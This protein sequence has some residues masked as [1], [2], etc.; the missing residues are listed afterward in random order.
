MMTVSGFRPI[1]TFDVTRSCPLR[2][3][4]C[5]FYAAP[6]PE[7]DLDDAAFLDHA[8]A[9]RDRHGIRSA[10]WVG[11]EPLLRLPLLRRVFSL[12]PRNAVST[13]G[14]VPIP[15][16]LDA[17]LLVSVDGPRDVHDRLRGTGAFDCLMSHVRAL[18]RG[19]FA[20]SVTL[21]SVSAGGLAHLPALVDSSGA[22]GAVVGFYVGPRGDPL[23]IDGPARSRAVDDLVELMARHPGCI[24]N[25]PASVEMFRPGYSRELARHCI[26]R[27]RAIAFDTL[28]RPKRPC[29]F[30]QRASCDSCGCPVVATQRA[31]ENGDEMSDALL[32]VLFPRSA[33]R[34]G[35]GRD[36]SPSVV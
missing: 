24:L 15:T 6:L 27:D 9:A 29:T 18:P 10:F 3:N 32:R 23:R 36:L 14:M 4:H 19:R 25:S 21:T 8:R 28:L 1:A 22:V 26:Y 5:Y 13:S 31:R 11:G 16:D 20:L 7:R 2:C 35:E 30:G 17:G 12:F 33:G 34:G